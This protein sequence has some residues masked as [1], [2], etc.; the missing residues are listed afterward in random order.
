MKK[1]TVALFLL[2]ACGITGFTQNILP[3]SKLY[4]RA[5][6][7]A[8]LY[9]SVPY[10]QYNS[11][12]VI[13]RLQLGANVGKGEIYLSGAYGTYRADSLPSFRSLMLT[14][15]Y[16]HPIGL[17]KKLSIKPG[18]AFG[19]HRIYIDGVNL[20]AFLREESELLLEASLWIQTP[21]YRNV[22]ISAGAVVQRT[23]FHHAF[24]AV[25]LGVAIAYSFNTPALLKK[26]ID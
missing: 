11:P 21:L 19:T 2:V 22:F 15:G 4:I 20:P 26:V 23:M 3:L 8:P 18:I 16:A 9:V 24:D 10:D 6:A 12:S 14:F 5:E 7:L 17:T 25:N 1:Y 13:P